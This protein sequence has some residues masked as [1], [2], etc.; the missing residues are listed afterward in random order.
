MLT[1]ILLLLVFDGQIIMD[2]EDREIVREG[3]VTTD[4]KYIQ[5]HVP[6]YDQGTCSGSMRT[7]PVVNAYRG[8]KSVPYT[9]CDTLTL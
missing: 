2:N 6:P 9:T 4:G 5:E 8:I 1:D 3:H 7:R